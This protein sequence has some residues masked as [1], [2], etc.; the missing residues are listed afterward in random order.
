MACKHVSVSQHACP[1]SQCLLSSNALQNYAKAQRNVTYQSCYFTFCGVLLKQ[2]DKR[3]DGHEVNGRFSW[4]L[5]CTKN[6]WNVITVNSGKGGKERV[7]V[8]GVNADK[9]GGNLSYTTPP[10][11]AQRDRGTSIKIT[12]AWPAAR[13]LCRQF[14]FVLFFQARIYSETR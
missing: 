2:K 14:P 6:G 11:G 3:T 13:K 7:S 10:C 8:N 12:S 1:Q 5:D 9:G 4:L